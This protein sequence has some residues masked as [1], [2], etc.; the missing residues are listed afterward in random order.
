MS[1]S[2]RSSVSRLFASVVL[3]AAALAASGTPRD[4]AIWKGNEAGISGLALSPDGARLATSGLDGCVRLWDTASGTIL[5]VLRSRDSE[6][7]AVAFSEA[8]KLVIATG[9]KGALTLF[10]ARSGKIV[11]EIRGL[12]GWSVDLAVSPDGRRVAAWSMDGRILIWD[13]EVGGKPSVLEGDPNKWGLS[14]AW[15]PDGRILAAGRAAIALWDVEKGLR[16]GSLS[17]HTDFVRGMDFSQ[18]GRWL[19]SAGLDK[20]VRVWDLATRREL[21]CLKPEGFVHPSSKGPVTEPI[22]VPLLSAKFS[23]DGKT[24]ATA[25]ADRL[26]RLWEV[27]TGR[28]IRSFP[29][30][31]MTVTALVFSPDGKT[32]YS[33][34]LDKTVRIWH[35]GP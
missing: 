5:R 27:E 16:T 29:G 22:R 12:E 34:G 3:L 18:D 23:P 35:L 6:L 28:C 14:L 24:L 4:P 1:A 7:Y 17:G 30:H 20:T 21:C 33:A 9:D 26:V 10:D 19:A 32:V 8:G 15:S 11:R 13:I 25:G 31:T 2:A